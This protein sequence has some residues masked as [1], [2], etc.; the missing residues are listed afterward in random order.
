M[1]DLCVAC[2]SRNLCRSICIPCSSEIRHVYCVECRKYPFTRSKCPKG[3][4]FSASNIQSNYGC[5]C[6]RC[7]ISGSLK[8]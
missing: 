4:S 6:D 3:H 1:N 7:G 8:S 5:V 2:G